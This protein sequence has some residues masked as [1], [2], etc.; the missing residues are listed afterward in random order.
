MEPNQL[1]SAI[2]SL[3]FISGEPV[4][5]G[6]IAKICATGK[7]EIENAILEISAEF[8]SANRG[9]RIIRK[10]D[11]VQMVT[12]PQNSVFVEQLV[13]GELQENL[14]AAAL[15]VLSIVAYRGPVTRAAIESVRGVNCS[16][17]LRNLLL[18]G[19]IERK[20]NPSDAR[21]Y[22]YAVTFD[23]MRQLGIDELKKLPDFE[24]LSSDGR[25]DSII[26]NNLEIKEQ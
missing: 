11:E 3:L 8:E 16:Y 24:T 21:A 15:E 17:T 2:E 12:S 10:N 4:K 9:M 26:G 1:K 14:S 23:L 18:R 20:E 19:L 5:I 22:I 25:I 13:K 6:K 7:P